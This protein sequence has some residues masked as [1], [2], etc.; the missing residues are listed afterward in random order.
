MRAQAGGAAELARCAELLTEEEL[1]YCGTA[2]EAGV[3]RERVLARALVR[4]GR[5][6]RPGWPLPE[7]PI[8]CR[9]PVSCLPAML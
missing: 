1:Q 5:A 6:S 4:C 9:Q 8:V 7:G 3:Q 2:G